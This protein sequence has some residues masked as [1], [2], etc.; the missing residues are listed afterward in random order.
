MLMDE[1]NNKDLQLHNAKKQTKEL[2]KYSLLPH[3][4]CRNLPSAPVSSPPHEA[5]PASKSSSTPKV[6]TSPAEG[7]RS[8]FHLRCLPATDAGT[9]FS[10]RRLL[11]LLFIFL[12]ANLVPYIHSLCQQTNENINSWEAINEVIDSDEGIRWEAW[13]FGNLEQNKGSP[14][15]QK[16][17][18]RW[19]EEVSEMGSWNH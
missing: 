6:S 13:A 7:T 2:I 1:L 16:E 10:L 3:H 14:S 17:G 8:S 19:T 18:W 5:S 11:V 12:L 4:S 9:K 15:S